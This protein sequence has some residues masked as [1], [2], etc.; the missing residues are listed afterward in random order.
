MLTLKRRLRRKAIH[1]IQAV[2][3]VIFSLVGV[4]AWLRRLGRRP[5]PLRR[6]E[7]RRILVIRIDLLGDVVLSMPAVEALRAAYPTAHVAMLV[8]PFTRSVPEIS[9]AVDEVITLDTNRLRPGNLRAFL[10]ADSYREWISV[11]RH[12]RASK[13]DLCVSLCGLMASI[14]A[15]LSGAPHR[16]GYREE[17]YPLLFTHPVPGRRY[18]KGQHEVLY[19]LDLARA[20]GADSADSR[21]TLRAPEAAQESAARLLVDHGL[22]QE[23]AYAVVHAGATNGSAKRWPTHHWATLADLLHEQL[24]LWVVLTGSS[25]DGPL[26]EAIVG[27]ARS[28][29]ILLTGETTIVELAAVLAGAAIVLSGDSGPLHMA[30]ALSRPTVSLYGPTD[31]VLSGPY[32]GAGQPAVV[33]R[34]GI[35]CSPC[36]N[37]YETAECRFGNPVCMID[38]TPREV[39]AAVRTVLDAQSGQDGDPEVAR[40]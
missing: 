24:G 30:V 25:G 37:H 6:D 27:R 10:Q 38:I 28:R 9:A 3:Y 2:L 8:L 36:Y 22:A 33:L 14:L 29:P 5:P 31:P 26:A 4:V 23:Q 1:F 20:A 12:L 11:L 40:R 7:V 15:F 21:L 34:K 35:Y 16:V 39:F 13:F 18:K 32:P 19:C 17:S